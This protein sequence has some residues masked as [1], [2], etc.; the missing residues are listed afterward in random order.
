MVVVGA[1]VV[2]SKKSLSNPTLRIFS[3]MFSSKNFVILSF[4]FSSLIHFNLIF[5]YGVTSGP[6]LFFYT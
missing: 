4:K 1:S 5:V 3:P 6:T 2:I